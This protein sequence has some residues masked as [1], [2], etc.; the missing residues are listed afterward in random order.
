MRK[1]L[2][3]HLQVLMGTQPHAVQTAAL[4]VRPDDDRVLLL[5]SRDTGRWVLP[6]G[7]P[8][9]GKSLAQAALQEAWEEAG[10]IGTI[11]REEIGAF[12][13]NKKIDTGVWIPVNCVVHT[14]VVS[15]MKN[16]FPEAGQRTRVWF[17]PQEAADLVHEA[18]LRTLL[19]NLDQP[20][21]LFLMSTSLMD[22]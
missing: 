10:V 21:D 11:A 2:R 22:I 7:W 16:T 18:E 19:R 1:K 20:R 17:T 3:T 6:K 14:V 13:Y 8:M 12:R 4:C 5:T 15:K 9:R